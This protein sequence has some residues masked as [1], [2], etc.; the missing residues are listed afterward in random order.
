MAHG[1]TQI[2]VCWATPKP[3]TEAISPSKAH[4]HKP[5]G[6]LRCPM[7]VGNQT[8]DSQGVSTLSR[9]ILELSLETHQPYCPDNTPTAMIT[10]T[11]S[12]DHP[13]EQGDCCQ[14]MGHNPGCTGKAVQDATGLLLGCLEAQS[15]VGQG[16]DV[17]DFTGE[18]KWGK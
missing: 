14:G 9:P 3:I 18:Q 4:L 8:K 6:M 10:E 12:L 7:E 1:G 5:R 15:Q 2:I 11:S 17:G 13:S 16:R